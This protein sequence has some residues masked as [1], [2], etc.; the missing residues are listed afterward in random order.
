MHYETAWL[1]YELITNN[2]IHY[3]VTLLLYRMN[4]RRFHIYRRGVVLGL[5]D[6]THDGWR[7]AA[8]VNLEKLSLESFGSR[9][10]LEYYQDNPMG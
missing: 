8:Y 10:L 7:A 2:C 3:G 9:A 4:R 6:D 5:G 1:S